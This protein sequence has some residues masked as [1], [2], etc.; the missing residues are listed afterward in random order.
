MG[1]FYFYIMKKIKKFYRQHYSIQDIKDYV[2]SNSINEYSIHRTR[3]YYELE[4]KR[5]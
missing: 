5:K 2:R 3:V 4:Y 1:V